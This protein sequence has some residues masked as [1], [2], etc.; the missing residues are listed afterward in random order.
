MKLQERIQAA[1][2]S[3]KEIQ[4]KMTDAVETAQ[5]VGM[6]K[7]D[8]INDKIAEAKGNANAAQENARIATERTKSK[9][10]SELLKAQMTINAAK[11]SITDKVE[12]MDKEHRK[13]R[14]EDLVV[15]AENCE[16]MAAALIAESKLALLEAAA[17]ALEYAEKYGEE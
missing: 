3:M 1:Q 6:L 4:A 2:D 17:E 12:T 13:A 15:Y 9:L 14:I 10:N 5:I 11:A 7:K 16:S 8:E